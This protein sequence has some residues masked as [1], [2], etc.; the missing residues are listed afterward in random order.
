MSENVNI[1]LV[2]GTV[3]L[4]PI[5]ARFEDELFS[6]LDDERVW[7]WLPVARPDA[8][9]FAELFGF[10]L[11]ENEAGRMRTWVTTAS[12]DERVLG[13]SSFLA[14][15]PEHRG[16]EVGWTMISPLAWGT[17]ANV[18]A[19]MLMLDHAFGALGCQRVEFKTDS[20]NERSRGAL[21]A[22][23]AQ[24]EG[25]FRRH[26]DTNYGVRDSAYYSVISS[27]WPE[28]R[29]NLEVRLRSSL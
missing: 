18:E 21:A 14:L 4:A 16:L 13:T 20:N 11:A 5:D 26:M 27:E 2:G 19:K 1:P 22:L 12:D 8:A 6:A 28:V 24:F 23:P 3:T 25:I 17:G 10:L 7:K 29:A 15:R 9:G